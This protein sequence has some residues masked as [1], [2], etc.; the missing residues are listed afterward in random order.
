VSGTTASAE[1]QFRPNSTIG[2]DEEVI[3]SDGLGGTRSHLDERARQGQRRV[4]GNLIFQ[5]NAA[6]LDIL[7]H[8]A[9]GGVK[10]TNTIPLA[11]S[12]PTAE[13]FAVRDGTVY[14]YSACVVDTL[15]ITCT[16]GGPLEAAISIIGLDE[17]QEG[18]MGSAAIDV[19]TPPY[20]WADESTMTIGGSSYAFDAFE[21]TVQNFIETKWRSGSLT[22]AA[23][24]PTDRRVAVSLGLSQGDAIAA[25]GSAAAGAAVVAAFTNSVV[26]T[27]SLSFSMAK[28]RAPRQP[29][30]FGERGILG[31]PWQG[32][33]RKSGSTAELVTTNDSTV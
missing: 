9:L 32:V 11:E 21:L 25:Y 18:S 2:L 24:Q 19:A 12:L 5:P 27:V 10:S 31:L 13:W 28:V 17:V 6:E 29:L 22:P 8:L 4:V 33:A 14:H 15:T 1:L 30:P 20:T 23:L 3:D 16:A 7:L 26:N